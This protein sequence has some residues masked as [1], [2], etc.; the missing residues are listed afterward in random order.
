EDFLPGSL[1]AQ[2]AGFAGPKFVGLPDR[3][4]IHPAIM[5]ETADPRFLCKP[6]GRFEDARFLQMGLDVFFHESEMTLTSGYWPLNGKLATARRVRP[7]F[8]FVFC[9][10]SPI[11]A[12]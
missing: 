9:G 12:A 1:P 10:C 6:V 7:S 8:A 5:L 2:F 3:L 11:L 4:A